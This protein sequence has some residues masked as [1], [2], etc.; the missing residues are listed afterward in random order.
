[1]R[2]TLP[3]LV[4]HIRT[5][6]STILPRGL[7]AAGYPVLYR[8]LARSVTNGGLAHL[9]GVMVFYLHN[10]SKMAPWFAIQ[11]TS[12]GGRYGSFQGSF[13][14]DLCET[15]RRVLR[16]SLENAMNQAAKPSAVANHGLAFFGPYGD[17][18]N[19]S[20]G[21]S[22]SESMSSSRSDRCKH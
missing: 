5:V 12:G 14:H 19:S 21:R 10:A 8:S 17:N 4:A 6:H 7:L 16:Y 3:R 1:M 13:L 20:T 11:R 15:E 9:P 22:I 18:L 2:F